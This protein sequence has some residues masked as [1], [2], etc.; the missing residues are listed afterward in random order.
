MDQESLAIIDEIH[1][2]ED[3]FQKAKKLLYLKVHKKIRI[4][5]LATKLQ[6]KPAYLC[7]ILRLNKLP[8]I[9]RDGYYSKSVSLSHLFIIA[10]LSTADDMML[11]YE[12][13][14][15][16]TLTASQTEDLIREMMYD[17]N[18]EGEYVA[19]EDITTI[20]NSLS[21]LGHD[22]TVKMIQTRIRGKLIIEI[23]GGLS[24]TTPALH[25]VSQRMKG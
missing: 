11:A 15:T 7:H 4:K 5:D 8:E 14:L 21:S 20:R 16:N 10:R 17:I 18:S 6:I 25:A 3:Y 13:V 12:K 9:V 19:P 2:E 1:H 23:K 24:K 22:Y